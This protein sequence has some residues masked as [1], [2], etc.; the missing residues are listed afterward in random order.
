M[1]LHKKKALALR[2]VWRAAFARRTRLSSLRVLND[3]LGLARAHC[4]LVL[5]GRPPPARLPLHPW[6]HPPILQLLSNLAKDWPTLQSGEQFRPEQTT[7]G[8]TD[9]GP[10]LPLLQVTPLEMRRQQPC[11]TLYTSRFLLPNPN[12]LTRRD[13]KSLPTPISRFYACASPRMTKLLII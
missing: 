10:S 2:P 13:G 7:G 12:K 9:C 8:T 3:D 6:L 11:T 1:E 4:F 5:P